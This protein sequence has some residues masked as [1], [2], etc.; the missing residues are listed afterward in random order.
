MR[1]SCTLRASRRVGTEKQWLLMKLFWGMFRY[2]PGNMHR[3]SVKRERL[4][5]DLKE[6]QV[7]NLQVRSAI[8]GYILPC[9]LSVG[10]F[11][12]LH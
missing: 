6:V 12:S 9:Q 1:S 10:G 4:N 7:L 5:I 2:L 11:S 8:Q 3:L